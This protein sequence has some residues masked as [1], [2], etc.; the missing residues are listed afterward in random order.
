M[1]NYLDAFAGIN[2][3]SLIVAYISAVG[4]IVFR[5]R[6]CLCSQGEGRQLRMGSRRD[7]SRM[8]NAFTAALPRVVEEH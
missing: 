1:T 4:L 6:L 2:E 7:D 3:I 5:S 8:D